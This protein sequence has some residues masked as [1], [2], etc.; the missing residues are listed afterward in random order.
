M[1]EVLRGLTIRGPRPVPGGNHCCVRAKVT[2]AAEISVSSDGFGQL[3][4]GFD[5]REGG[6]EKE[7]VRVKRNEFGSVEL[8][9]ESDFPVEWGEELVMMIKLMLMPVVEL[10]GG[11]NVREGEGQGIWVSSVPCVCISHIS[12]LSRDPPTLFGSEPR[13]STLSDLNLEK[14]SWDV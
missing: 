13:F 4:I 6:E 7:A 14:C 2:G 9:R 8:K 12:D 3:R 5:G 10:E 11:M 1:G